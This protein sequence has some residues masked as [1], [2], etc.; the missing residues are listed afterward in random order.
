MTTTDKDKAAAI[1]HYLETGEH[2]MLFPAW[3]GAN[4]LDRLKCGERDLQQALVAEV[5]RRPHSGDVPRAVRDMD[6]VEFAR[7]KAEPMVRGLF[8]KSE[9]NI[10]LSLVE[11]S[12][13]FLT[14]DTIESVITDSEWLS[15]AWKLANMYLMSLNAEPLN[16]DAPR[17]VGL[18]EG[19]RSY[20]PP[21]YFEETHPFAD[22]VVHETAHIF[23]NCRC[24][25]VGLPETPERKYPLDIHFSKRETFAYACEA[26]SRILERSNTPA[27]RCALA[28]QF[29][30]FNVDDHRVDATEVADI[31]RAACNRRN[32]WKVILAYCAAEPETQ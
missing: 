18:S 26:Y 21:A 9:Q 10:V 1:Q 24:H 27:E 20:V 16:Q 3:T 30:G 11:K 2:D 15:S 25:E 23:H 8:P 14:P 22:F 4:V 12:V 29:D 17:I 5:Q 19:T 32:G 6:L 13:V 31:V 28:Q 7:R